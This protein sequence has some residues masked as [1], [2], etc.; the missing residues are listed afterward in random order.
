[1]QIESRHSIG[2]AETKEK[3]KKAK[4]VGGKGSEEVVTFERSW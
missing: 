3:S 4:V 2:F 1:L